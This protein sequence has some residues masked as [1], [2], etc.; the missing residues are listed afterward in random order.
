MQLK[1]LKQDWIQEINGVL[2]QAGD[3]IKETSIAKVY[4]ASGERG[5]KLKL[6]LIGESNN[7]DKK[8]Y[9]YM[10]ITKK[11][12]VKKYN[13]SIFANMQKDFEEDTKDYKYLG[14]IS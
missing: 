14:H 12:E 5:M 6:W 10:Y 13:G 7:S 4:D 11:C 8:Y 3:S 2:A 9:Y 1:E